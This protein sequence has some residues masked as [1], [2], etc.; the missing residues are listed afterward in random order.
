MTV[1]QLDPV[2]GDIVTSGVQFISG[3]EEVAQTVRTRLNLFLGEYFRDITDGTPWFEQVL[4]KGSSLAT[5]EA[6]IK[7]RIVRTENVTRL[8]SFDTDFDIATRV[9]IVTTGILTPFGETQI[10]ITGGV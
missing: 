1:R 10:T 7:N 5:K 8:T 6:V 3:A 2:T 4:G 9:Y